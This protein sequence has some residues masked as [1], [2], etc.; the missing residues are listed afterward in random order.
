MPT[1]G[2]RCSSSLGIRL[3]YAVSSTEMPS[4][5]HHKQKKSF[6]ETDTILHPW[7]MPLAEIDR[8]RYLGIILQDSLKWNHHVD[9]TCKKA[10]TTSSFLQ[11]NIHD[12]PP[13]TKVLCYNALVLP[14][15][16]YAS[17]VWDP[18]TQ[19]E[20]HSKESAWFTASPVA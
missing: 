8:A 2:L 4:H 12:C 6:Q 18:F 16:Q 20:G 5:A 14:V 17:V 15:L 10:S 3:S 19:K 7:Y 9:V 13:R 11:R 1:E